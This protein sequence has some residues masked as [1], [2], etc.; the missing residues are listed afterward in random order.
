MGI[1]KDINGMDL[2]EADNIKRWLEYTEKLYKN[3]IPYNYT[4]EVTNR[5]K[6]IDLIGREPEELWMEHH[7][8]VQQAMIKIIPKKKKSKKGKMVV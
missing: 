6:G 4:V 5:F 7:N 8:I 2:T 3:R 1:I